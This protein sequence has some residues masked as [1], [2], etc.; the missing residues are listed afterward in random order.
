[1]IGGM[2]FVPTDLNGYGG[3]GRVKAGRRP[4]Q[5]AA[6]SG[7]DAA[8]HRGSSRRDSDI[9]LRLRLFCLCGMAPEK[10]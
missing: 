3:A 9:S 2:P 7:L 6:R 5:E 8:E 1:M 10:R 4:S